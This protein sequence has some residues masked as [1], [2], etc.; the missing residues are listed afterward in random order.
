MNGVRVLG[1]VAVPMRD[2]VRLSADVYLPL[3]SGDPRDNGGSDGPFPVIL[4]R[5]P[6]DNNTEP[7]IRKGR[8]LASLGYARARPG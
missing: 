7:N 1:D 4:H 3:E 2:G 6:Y 5:T 8:R